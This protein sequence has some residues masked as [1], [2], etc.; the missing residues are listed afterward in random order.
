MRSLEMVSRARLQEIFDD[1]D[2]A[3]GRWNSPKTSLLASWVRDLAGMVA[4]LDEGQERNEA[5]I[6][7]L[8]DAVDQI[9]ARIDGIAGEEPDP[10]DVP[11]FDAE[12]L[13][14]LDLTTVPYVVDYDLGDN[15]ALLHKD[16]LHVGPLFLNLLEATTQAHKPTDKNQFNIGDCVRLA[17]HDSEHGTYHM[18]GEAFFET[19]Y[20]IGGPDQYGDYRVLF[21]PRVCK[22]FWV[23]PAMLDLVPNVQAAE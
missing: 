14:T 22:A 1:A 5:E 18:P 17:R 19:G 2:E 20:V 7:A 21:Y 12:D 10:L 4:A 6:G 15:V 23:K 3:D 13:D 8:S 9:D 11:D 16:K